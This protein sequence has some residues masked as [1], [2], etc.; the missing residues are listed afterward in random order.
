LIQVTSRE[1]LGD[2]VVRLLKTSFV[3]FTEKYFSNEIPEWHGSGR[4]A[5][6]NKNDMKLEEVFPKFIELKLL[7]AGDYVEHIRKSKNQLAKSYYKQLPSVIEQDSSLINS[8]VVSARRCE[9]T[10][11]RK[12]CTFLA[13]RKYEIQLT[14]LPIEN[15]SVLYSGERSPCLP[16]PLIRLYPPSFVHYR[17]SIEASRATSKCTTIFE[18][19]FRAL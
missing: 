7:V 1:K 17:G 18:L 9:K 8:L 16:R 5:Q 13:R 4:F 14:Q 3:L 19:P 12:M 2:W 6:T 11:Q 15:F 10:F